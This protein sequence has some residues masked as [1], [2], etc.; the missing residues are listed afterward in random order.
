MK[1]PRITW[2]RLRNGLFGKLEAKTAQSIGESPPF[3]GLQFD[4]AP[5]VAAAGGKCQRAGWF[6]ATSGTLEYVCCHQAPALRTRGSA[7]KAVRRMPEVFI[8]PLGGV[9]S[10]LPAGGTSPKIYGVTS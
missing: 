5:L 3:S 7:T 6:N 10:V 1:N 8:S 9:L 4:A 2:N